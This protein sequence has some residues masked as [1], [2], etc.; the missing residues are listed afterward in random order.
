MPEALYDYEVWAKKK[1]SRRMRRKAAAMALALL[2]LALVI[3]A[4]VVL[5]AVK[6]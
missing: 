5:A 3:S 1:D 4:G 6:T 2:A